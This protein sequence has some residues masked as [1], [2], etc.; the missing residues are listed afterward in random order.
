MS[1]IIGRMRRTKSSHTHCANI[2]RSCRKISPWQGSGWSP[3]RKVT[4]TSISS[5]CRVRRRRHFL[6]TGLFNRLHRLRCQISMFRFGDRGFAGLSV[7]LPLI[8]ILALV[9]SSSTVLIA[10]QNNRWQTLDQ[11][12][13]SSHPCGQSLREW[14]LDPKA[15]LPPLGDYRVDGHLASSICVLAQTGY[16]YGGFVCDGH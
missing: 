5:H 6:S 1:M 9:W 3:A 4:S 13:A 7:W 10:Y 16:Q 2:Q 8:P 15:C 12:I 11:Q 14:M